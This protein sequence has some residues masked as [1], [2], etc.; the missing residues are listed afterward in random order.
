M[1]PWIS[2]TDRRKQYFRRDVLPS[3]VSPFAALAS[4][5]DLILPRLF[6]ALRST[7]ITWV[8]PIPSAFSYVN[9]TLMSS[10]VPEHHF[11]S[12]TSRMVVAMFLST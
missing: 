1:G 11:P 9:G 3:Y 2:G 10:Y 12:S 8:G 6:Q 7:T 4:L 5:R